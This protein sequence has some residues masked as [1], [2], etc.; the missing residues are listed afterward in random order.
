[1]ATFNVS[2][3]ATTHAATGRVPYVV[4]NV[5][6]IG[7]VNSNA[8]I[9]A[10]GILQVISVPAETLVMDAGFEVLTALTGTAPDIDLGITGGDVDEWVD[11]NNGTAGYATRTTASPHFTFVGTTADTIDLLFNTNAAT[12]GVIRVVAV[13][14]DIKGIR[15]TESVSDTGYDTAL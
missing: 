13:L 1:M 11:G 5:V 6:D 9:G 12:A 10:A 3:G 8:G 4:E 2:G 15:E 14:C 7:Q